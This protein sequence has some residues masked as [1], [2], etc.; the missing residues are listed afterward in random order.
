[1]TGRLE[2][3]EFDLEDARQTLENDSREGVVGKAKEVGEDAYDFVKEGIGKPGAVTVPAGAGAAALTNQPVEV[4]AGAG[5]SASMLYNAAKHHVESEYGG[6]D[7]KDAG[8]IGGIAGMGPV[9]GYAVSKKDEVVEAAGNA[10][11]SATDAAGEAY[12]AVVDMGA[13]AANYAATH[14]PQLVNDVA[15][16]SDEAALGVGA[17]LATMLGGAYGLSKVEDKLGGEEEFEEEYG[18]EEW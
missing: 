8:V 12:G 14:G 6:L 11:D 4:G 1:M 16:S 13:D 17:G 7:A 18:E 2:D 3:D 9:G 10:V 5:L 15:A